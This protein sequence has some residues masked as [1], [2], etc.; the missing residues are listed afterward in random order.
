MQLN[1]H[2]SPDLAGIPLIGD[3]ATTERQRQI[4][5]LVI[6]RQIMGRPFMAPPGLPPDRA[7]A[8]RT[9]FDE[10]MKDPEF[11]AEANTRGQEVSPVSGAT[12]DALIAELYATPKDVVE[13]TK[14]AISGN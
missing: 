14:R 11:V 1:A 4:V 8:L 13:E 6:S 7:A 9:A 5:K 12:L 10:T 2:S 3:F